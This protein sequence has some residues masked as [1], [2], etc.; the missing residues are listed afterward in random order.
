MCEYCVHAE[1]HDFSVANC[2]ECATYV[3]DQEL[4][5][6]FAFHHHW[7]FIENLYF[8][9]FILKVF[10]KILFYILSLLEA[11]RKILFYDSHFENFTLNV[12]QEKLFISNF[13]LIKA[14]YFW[15][16]LLSTSFFLEYA[17]E[18]CK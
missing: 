15:L 14:F 7:K 16:I 12:N 3:P 17:Q 5:R 10:R 4:V 8:M 11:S 2:K 13:L 18:A 9:I 6:F 1:C